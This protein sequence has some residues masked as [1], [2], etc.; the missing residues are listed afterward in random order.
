MRKSGK[1]YGKLNIKDEIN[2]KINSINR[3]RN[4]RI[5]LS[6]RLKKYYQRWKLAFFILNFEAVFLI[7]KALQSNYND[8]KFSLLSAFFSI[9]VILLQYFINEQNYNERS[10]KSHYHQLELEDI[11]LK[12]KRLIIK[13]NA[14]D[15]DGEA[16][17]HSKKIAIY[18]EIMN[19]YQMML[20]N[21]ENHSKKDNILMNK[22][23]KEKKRFL[24]DKDYSMD[25]VFLFVNYIIGFAMLI[26]IILSL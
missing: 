8:L 7:I 14:E 25:S 21:N 11:I 4:N 18:K 22:A 19:D 20:K 9:Y 15:K 6:E 10:L 1:D 3:T 2:K 26:F 12:F 24:I 13:I 23:D 17:V 5:G 16:I